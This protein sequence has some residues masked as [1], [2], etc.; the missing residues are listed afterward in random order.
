MQKNKLL[1]ILGLTLFCLSQRTTYAQDAVSDTISLDV[2][3]L[4]ELVVEN[5]PTLKVMAKE[6]DLSK[7]NVKVTKNN[8]LPNANTSVS[9]FYLSDVDVLSPK[10]KKVFKED[11][12]NFGNTASIEANQLLWKGGQVREGIK[13]SELQVD[14]ANLQYTSGE[15]EARLAALGYYLD[16]YKLH[17]QSK[18]YQQNINLAEQRLENINKFWDQGM[19]TRNDVIRGELMVSNLKLARLSVDNGILIINKQLNIAIGLDENIVVIPNEDILN[20]VLIVE[21][22]KEYQQMALQSNPNVML[23]KKA[24]D[25]NESVL[26]VTKKNWY[27]ALAAFAGN[28]LQRPLTSSTPAIDMYANTWNAGL[29]LSFDIGTLWKNKKEVDLK[30]IEVE[31]AIIQQEEVEAYISIAVKAA[32]IK[33]DEALVQK[34]TLSINKELADENYRIMERKYNNQLAI[35]IDLIDAANAKLDAELQYANSEVNVIYAY[36]KLLKEAGRI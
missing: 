30:I 18:V 35:I 28:T 10:F 24:V 13:I 8:L 33:H 1:T 21:E 16:L 27:P 14:I 7:Q 22:E 5:N 17:N 34:N 23:T 15:Q 19:I 36:Y 2:Q 6:I 12:P 9:A 20:I 26:N 29:G 31:K 4:F 11:L 3:K 32:H 25:I